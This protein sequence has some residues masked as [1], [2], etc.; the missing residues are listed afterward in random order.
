MALLSTQ[1]LLFSL[2]ET[3]G[4]G[5]DNAT[6]VTDDYKELD[7]AFTGK[8]LKVVSRRDQGRGSRRKTRER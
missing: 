6:P 8:I 4:V 3:A 2:D 7:N 1:P 5:V